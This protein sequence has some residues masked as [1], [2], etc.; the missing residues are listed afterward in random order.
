MFLSVALGKLEAGKNLI[1]H[2]LVVIRCTQERRD[3]GVRGL[4]AEVRKKTEGRMDL[5]IRQA[6]N[7]LVGKP[8]YPTRKRISTWNSR[9]K[10]LRLV[11][12]L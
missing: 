12:A 5:G 11:L 9:K 3:R 7:E 8:V 10:G 2:R 4:P 1:R 6:L